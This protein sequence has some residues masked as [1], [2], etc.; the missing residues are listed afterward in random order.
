MLSWIPL[1][2]YVAVLSLIGI[3]TTYYTPET[4]GRDLDD[5]RDAG[6]ETGI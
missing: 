4:R 5:L 3:V 2:C 1:A 6:Q